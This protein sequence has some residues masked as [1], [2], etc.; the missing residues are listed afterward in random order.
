MAKWQ[1]VFDCKGC[2][3]YRGAN[4]GRGERFCNYAVDEGKCRVINGKVVPAEKCFK[5]K[6]FFE[7]K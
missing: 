5:D 4:G 1:T 6:I 2:K 3:Y 7:R